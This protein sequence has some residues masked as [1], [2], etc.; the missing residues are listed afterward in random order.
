[1]GKYLL[2]F[3]AYL[4]SFVLVSTLLPFESDTLQQVSAGEEKTAA[5]ALLVYC[6]VHTA[7]ISYVMNKASW[8]GMPLIL[9]LIV[10]TFGLQT[11]MPQIELFIFRSAFPSLS[12]YDIG[13]MLLRGLLDK[14]LFVPLAAIV[15]GK[16]RPNRA[17]RLKSSPGFGD[18]FRQWQQPFLMLPAVYV[19]LYFAFGYYVAWQFAEVRSFYGVGTVD[20]GPLV[21]LQYVRGML[22]IVFAFPVILML[23]N[24][25]RELTIGLVLL[26]G[27]LVVA[28]L[29]FPNPLMPASIR[30]PHF[31]EVLLSNSLY[32]FFISRLFVLKSPGRHAMLDFPERPN[33]SLQADV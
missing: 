33:N 8:R 30:G 28:S 21:L 16:A 19:V 6:A 24:R 1:M 13:M 29:V 4:V 26:L 3:V 10:A 18:Y 15:L 23:Q 25:Q 17:T 14:V 32:G 12:N 11:F 2:L 9:G 22:W 31:V 27:L 5:L 20:N 7:I